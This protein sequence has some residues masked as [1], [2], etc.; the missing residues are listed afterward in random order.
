VRTKVT[1]GERRE[2]QVRIIDGVSEGDLVVTAGQIK[3]QDGM[4]VQVVPPNGGGAGAGGANPPGAA[5]PNAGQGGA[6]PGG[7]AAG[8]SGGSAP[9]G[10]GAGGGQGG[11]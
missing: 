10:G 3:V 4:P 9:G 2:G 7:A 8:A 6:A 1:V 5:A 11:R